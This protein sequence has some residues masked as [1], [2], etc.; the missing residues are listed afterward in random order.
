MKNKNKKAQEEMIG[1]ALILIIVSVIILIFITIS[2][3]KTNQE[4]ES[5]EVDS[6]IQALA[7]YTTN[8]SITYYPDYLDVKDLI[9]QCSNGKTCLNGENTCDVL[10]ITLSNLINNSWQ[11]G[12]NRPN[13]GYFFNSTYDGLEVFSLK[14]GNM[15][16]NN[17]GASQIFQE[18][19]IY[20]KVYF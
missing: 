17:K 12:E 15:T 13:K 14:Q 9:K 1:F 7:Q 10:N 8:C 20:F 5:Y 16:L 6:F 19:E 11:V 18:L 3:R 2:L 4:V